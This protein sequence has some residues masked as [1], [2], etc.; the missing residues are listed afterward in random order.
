MEVALQRFSKADLENEDEMDMGD[1]N[2]LLEE[3]QLKNIAS[4]AAKLKQINAIKDIKKDW[5]RK[6]SCRH[7][8]IYIYLILMIWKQTLLVGTYHA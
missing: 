7:S 3:G 6:N 2:L 8:F 1:S 4:E 5:I